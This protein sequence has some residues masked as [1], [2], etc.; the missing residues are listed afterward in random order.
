M[1]N[2]NTILELL[3]RVK[4]EQSSLHLENDVLKLKT[5]KGNKIS[6]ALLSAIKEHKSALIEILRQKEEALRY[7]D[8]IIRE[9]I[10]V[11]DRAKQ[12]KIPLTFSQKRLWFIDQFEGST[13]Y[14]IPILL[15]LKGRFYADAFDY[16]WRKIVERH[17]VF[18]TCFTEVEGEVY[19]KILLP[20]AWKI[21]YVD[22]SSWSEEQLQI[23][24]SNEVGTPFDLSKDYMIRIHV[25]KISENRT[26]LVI[27]YHHIAIDGWSLAIVQDEFLELYEAYRMN[28]E[29]Q[30]PPLKIQYADYAL[31]QNNHLHG[32][33]LDKKLEWWQHYLKGVVPLDLPIDYP[34]PPVQSTRGAY[35]SFSITGP[36]REKLYS[37][38]ARE[39]AT[40][41]MVLLA[42]FKVLLYKYTGQTDICV[43]TPVAN[44]TRKE[45]EKVIGFFINSLV[46]RSD[47][48]GNPSFHQ[49]L[50]QLKKNA[51]KA[52]QHQDV[53][54]DL[55][56]EKVVKQRDVS[57]RPLFQVLFILQNLP[58]GEEEEAS[59]IGEDVEVEFH[60]IGSD[61]AKFDLS[62]IATET[63]TEINIGI[64]YCSDLFKS[65]TIAGM[66][67]H[68][69]ELMS[70]IV[71]NPDL[72]IDS[73]KMLSEGEEKQILHTFNQEPVT[74]PKH[75][76][77]LD[78]FQQ[79][80][81]R[82]PNAV[83]VR[84]NEQT[85]T[86]REL[87]E[88]ANRVAHFLK[89]KGL[90]KDNYVAL[91]LEYCPE[92]IVCLWGIMKAGAAYV[93]VNPDYPV[94]QIAFML[95]ETEASILLTSDK[96][97]QQ[98]RTNLPKSQC[99]CY[100]WDEIRT[101]SASFSAESPEI[102][103]NHEQIAYLIF[104][105]GSTGKPKGVLIS[106]GAM[107]DY[108]QSFQA[109]FS[110]SE[111][112]KVI[113]QSSISFDTMV[114][115]VF[116]AL[117]SGAS[118]L[119]VPEG[120]KNILG[121]KK[122][123]QEYGATILTTTPLVLKWLG[124]VLEDTAQL[125]CIIS[126][127][128]L[129]LPEQ[130]VRFFGKTEIFNTYGPSETTVCATYHPIKRL[131]ES[132]MIG[133]PIRNRELYIMSADLQLLPVGVRGEICIGGKGLA[134]GYLSNDRLSREKFV[135]HPFKAGEKLYRTGDYGK[136]LPDGSVVFLGRVDD[137]IKLRGYR[138]ELGE[139]AHTLQMYDQ[140]K[141][142]VVNL[143]KQSEGENLLV[144]YVVPNGHFDQQKA[145][146][147]LAAKLPAYMLPSVYMEIAEV[148][149]NTNNKVDK[150]RLP[151]P[152]LQLDHSEKDSLPGNLVEEKLVE[153]WENMLERDDIGVNQNFFEL[154]GHSLM[155][156]EL[157]YRITEEFFI[158]LS[159]KDIFET[160]TIGKLAALIDSEAITENKQSL[161][162]NSM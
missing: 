118:L 40:L 21:N 133:K 106:H 154:G 22:A 112:D 75:I 76:S 140:V 104:T 108:V 101:E 88:A 107:L 123:I 120:G 34:R 90:G 141:D 3:E 132:S 139:I 130:I 58:A 37:L 131:Q 144:A 26:G 80:V 119:I 69:I 63:P 142:C 59:K 158:R 98:I 149:V 70:A 147:F 155:A 73:L 56:V 111:T 17:E 145:R 135:D 20:E 42:G 100:S 89:E 41:F 105:S 96:H 68:Y 125:R 30:L 97:I 84:L 79:Q 36:L 19:Q 5:I 82:T 53:P 51:L 65:S 72:G 54:V 48:N 77:L 138:I 8:L 86:Y 160:G 91:S 57:I 49:C 16:A 4:N 25:L 71:R 114:E 143:W 116:P 103:L 52:Y 74:S 7:G 9:P 124:N 11:F 38:A 85:L 148:P 129:L 128:E 1:E 23:W 55:I 61:I 18:R 78:L 31:W 153:I 121:L 102:R 47:L 161:S 83:A 127:G 93:P 15:E 44:R 162:H 99:L 150:H 137:Q 46:L 126:G 12:S 27:L 113:Q 146:E 39:R 134:N 95:A 136:W 29:P 35:H 92:L 152:Q 64:E 28:R 33:L 159:V 94:E 10:E 157:I 60:G 24:T 81:A 62:F 45:L 122:C 32:E 117:I 115:E 43:G 110:I 13:H 14:H 2:P 151:A 50:V 109:Y 66:A 6:P 87:N 156:M 67:T